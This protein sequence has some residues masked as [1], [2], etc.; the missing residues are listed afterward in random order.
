[1]LSTLPR[2]T[3]VTPTVGRAPSHSP[4]DTRYVPGNTL[5]RGLG[6]FSV[7]LGLA[8]LLAPRAVGRLTGVRQHGLLQAHGARELACGVGILTSTRPAG[9]LWARVAG[10]AVDLAT[11]GANLPGAD[12]DRRRRVEIAT[13]AVLGVTLLDVLCG[14]AATAVARMEP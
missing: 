12:A 7:G 1:M 13:A 9:W 14:A 2:I 5:V 3:S 8:E 11:L 4:P 6:W 10:D